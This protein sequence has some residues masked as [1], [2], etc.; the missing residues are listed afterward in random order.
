MHCFMNTLARSLQHLLDTDSGVATD[1]QHQSKCVTPLNPLFAA[2]SVLKWYNLHLDSHSIPDEVTQLARQGL[3]ATAV[4]A[5]GLGFAVL[6]RCGEDFYFL[7]VCTWRQS[8]EL[9]QTV[10][11]KDGL[12]APGFTLFPRDEAHKP[13]LCVW[14]LVPVQHEQQAWLRFL[15]SARDECAAQAWLADCFSGTTG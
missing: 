4:H 2:G 13:M 5:L 6:H 10:L 11:Y 15:R 8:N 1:Y 14:E 12:A 9:W 7:V 3:L